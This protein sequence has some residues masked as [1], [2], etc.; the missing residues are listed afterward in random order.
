MFRLIRTGAKLMQS[1]NI[2]MLPGSLIDQN[3]TVLPSNTLVISTRVLRIVY[4][5]VVLLLINLN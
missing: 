2:R 3:R 4:S 1:S 5:Y